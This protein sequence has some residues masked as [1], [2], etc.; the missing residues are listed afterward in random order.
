[1]YPLAFSCFEDRRHTEALNLV[2]PLRIEL[3]FLVYQTN[4][5][6]VGRW[7]NYLVDGDGISPFF[8]STFAYAH[9]RLYLSGNINSLDSHTGPDLP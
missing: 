8:I 5:L 2:G 6:T 1:M 7:A 4:A 9:T 3:R